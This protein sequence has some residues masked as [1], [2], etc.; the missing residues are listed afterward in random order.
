[1]NRKRTRLGAACVGFAAL[2]LAA[3]VYAG[4]IPVTFAPFVSAPLGPPDCTAE[5]DCSDGPI[6]ITAGDFNDDGHLDVATANN[7]SDDVTVFLGDGAGALTTSFTASCSDAPAAIAAGNLDGGEVLDLVVSKELGN[8]IGVFIGNGDGT[9]ADEVVY[10]M[11][12]SPEGIVL[13]DF[14]EDEILDVATADLFGNT[15]SV[16][17]GDGDGTFGE[18]LVTDVPGGPHWMA[19][20]RLDGNETLDLA[21][22]L[23]DEIPAGLL[24]LLG[25]GDGTFVMAGTAAAVVND[26]PRG[27]TLA[28]F[29]GD[30]NL[31]AGVATEAEDLVDVLLGN[32]DGTFGTAVSYEVGGFPES[33]VAGDY[34]GDGIVDLASADSFGTLDFDGSV[35][36]LVGNGDGTFQEAVSFEVDPGAYGLVAADLDDDRLPD[37][38]TANLDGMTISILRNTGTPPSPSCVGDCNG[39]GTVSINE[40]IVGVNIAL[41]TFSVDECVAFDANGDGMV[42]IN[43]LIQAVNN[44]LG[45]CPEE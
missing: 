27:V 25:N 3:A 21:V 23:Y 7:L 14:N 33:V 35:S 29:N 4:L 1:M 45:G 10:E 36:V 34:N 17:L 15:V 8:S 39:D 2:V 26:S 32:G 22:T 11:G 13:A 28:D 42:G 38:V 44:A 5:E 41:G 37:I 40:L 12:N 16:R 18:R 30:D 6:D 9:F 20:G 24:T 19:V 43:E 31:D